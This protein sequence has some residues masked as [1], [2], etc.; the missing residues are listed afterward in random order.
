VPLTV[1]S[2]DWR[3]WSTKNVQPDWTGDWRLVIVSEDGSVLGSVK[4]AVN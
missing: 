3:T 4:F 1:R 2:G